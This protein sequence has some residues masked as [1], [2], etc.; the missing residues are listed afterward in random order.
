M[1]LLPWKLK[2][3]YLYGAL[4]SEVNTD[5]DIMYFM[6]LIIGRLFTLSIIDRFHYSCLGVLYFVYLE[7]LWAFPARP[8]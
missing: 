6:F 5:Y 8:D 7:N 2:L 4:T 1:H 3:A